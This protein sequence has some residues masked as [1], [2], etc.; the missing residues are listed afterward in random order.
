MQESS[1]IECHTESDLVF[2]FANKVMQFPM[3]K[4][5][6]SSRQLALFSFLFFLALYFHEV[7][8]LLSSV[9]FGRD[10]ARAVTPQSNQ[11]VTFPAAKKSWYSRQ[12]S[13]FELVHSTGTHYSM[14]DSFLNRLLNSWHTYNWINAI[15]ILLNQFLTNRFKSFK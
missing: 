2:A 12:H 7:C 5:N 13:A 6:P 9:H 3:R 14:S 15:R 4:T 8:L 10:V 1:R 11:T